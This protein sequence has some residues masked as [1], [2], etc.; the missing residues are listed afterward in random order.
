LTGRW[1][2]PRYYGDR[3][4]AA[5]FTSPAV[6]AVALAAGLWSGFD[7]L[8]NLGELPRGRV[9]IVGRRG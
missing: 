3:P 5:L 8:V 4:Q 9:L 7:A 1:G 2:Q 6:W